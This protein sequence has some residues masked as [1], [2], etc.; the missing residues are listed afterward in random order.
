MRGVRAVEAEGRSGASNWLPNTDT[1]RVFIKSADAGE[2]AVAARM[3]SRGMWTR[4]ASLMLMP[5]VGLR[6][7]VPTG[8]RVRSRPHGGWRAIACDPA[9]RAQG[10]P[11]VWLMPDL[12]HPIDTLLPPGPIPGNFVGKWDVKGQAR[13]LNSG[14]TSGATQGTTSDAISAPRG[15]AGRAQSERARKQTDGL[16]RRPADD[17]CADDIC[18]RASWSSRRQSPVPLHVQ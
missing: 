1:G 4:R 12:K 14:A 6:W 8:H 11:Y 16:S 7:M 10:T 3:S 9:C 18:Q 5:Y 15:D 17:A 13:Y 2:Y